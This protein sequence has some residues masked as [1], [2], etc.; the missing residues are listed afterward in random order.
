MARMLSGAPAPGQ[1]RHGARRAKRAAAVHQP[2]T[3]SRRAPTN[4]LVRQQLGTFA[5]TD[6]GET[7]PRVTPRAAPRSTNAGHRRTLR[8][9]DRHANRGDTMCARL[10][11]RDAAAD[12]GDAARDSSREDFVVARPTRYWAA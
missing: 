4:G 1:P 7:G 10:V 12:D 11:E 2:L 5:A 6:F 3:H 8:G 9:H